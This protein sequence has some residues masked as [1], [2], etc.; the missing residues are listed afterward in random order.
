MIP[1]IAAVAG[2]VA[3]LVIRQR[4]KVYEVQF[5]QNMKP[6]GSALLSYH[7]KHGSFPAELRLLEQDG[8]QPQLE[9]LLKVRTSPTGD[10]LYFPKANIDEPKDALLVSPPIQHGKQALV[11]RVDSSIQKEAKSDLPSDSEALRIPSP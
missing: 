9:E 1:V 5:T 4:E 6:I 7:E 11:M 2:L 8:L 10:W 3:P